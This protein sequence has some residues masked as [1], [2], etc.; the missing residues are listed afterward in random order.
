MSWK[1]QC[2]ILK[3]GL[4]RESRYNVKTAARPNRPSAHKGMQMLQRSV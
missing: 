4:T 3:A 2:T 1:S